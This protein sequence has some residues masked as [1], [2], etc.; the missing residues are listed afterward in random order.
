MLL[1]LEWNVTLQTPP[2]STWKR[3]FYY[4]IFPSREESL[5]PDQL[6]DIASAQ[7]VKWTLNL[8]QAQSC[9]LRLPPFQKIKWGHSESRERRGDV[10]C[11]PSYTS[12]TSQ[13][14]I[15]KLMAFSCS[16]AP[17]PQQQECCT[18]TGKQCM[19]SN[20]SKYRRRNMR[21]PQ[22]NLYN[23]SVVVFV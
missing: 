12:Y 23:L 1:G 17:F 18:L 3:V 9:I 19:M 2:W 6:G 4:F 7:Q 8:Q 16:Q 11:T 5:G 21:F 13:W 15:L 14:F 10:D 20:L 22:E